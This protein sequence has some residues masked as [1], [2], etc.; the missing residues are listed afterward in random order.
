MGNGAKAQQRKERGAKEAGKKGDPSQLKTNAAS[1]SI[2]CDICKAVF[3][4]TS[5]IV[6]YVSYVPLPSVTG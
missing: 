6:V 5:T 2:Q 3:Q 1:L 4:G